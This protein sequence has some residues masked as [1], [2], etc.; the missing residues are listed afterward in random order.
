[1]SPLPPAWDLLVVGNPVL[2][3][4]VLDGEEQ[5]PALGGTVAYAAVAL[6][7]LGARVAVVGGVGADLP[8]GLQRVLCHPNLDRTHLRLVPGVRSTCFRLEYREARAERVV[9]R[10]APGPPIERGAL[11]AALRGLRAVHL[12]AVA[13]ELT[14]EVLEALLALAPRPVLGADLHLLRRFDEGGALTLAGGAEE[15][16]R[17]ARLDVLKGSFEE[18]RALGG[19]S[20]IP[21]ALEALEARDTVP[22]TQGGAPGWFRD[23]ARLRRFTPCPA[24]E[25]DATGAGDV[26][27]ASYLYARAV[28][29]RAREDAV[30]FA[31]ACAA[32]VVEG[33]GVSRLAE[34]DR[35]AV[36]ERARAVRID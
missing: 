10:L 33:L 23:G 31:A 6:S 35:A 28:L 32:F 19:R 26:F 18:I 5:E 36:E 34:V 9:R 20:A 3:R 16:R 11:P 29:D 21:A 4:V 7:R 25:R 8:A 2:D 12:G 22:A 27:L 17:L 13:G 24:R 15:R 30:R 1:M 14:P